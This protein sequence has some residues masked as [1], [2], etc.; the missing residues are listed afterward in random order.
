[1]LRLWFILRFLGG[2]EEWLSVSSSHFLDDAVLI[3]C[4]WGMQSVICSNETTLRTLLKTSILQVEYVFKYLKGKR[5]G[6]Y[7]P[8]T[9]N[10]Y[11]FYVFDGHFFKKWG[12]YSVLIKVILNT[13]QTWRASLNF[14]GQGNI[15]WNGVYLA[16][17]PY[18]ISL[19]N[20]IKTLLSLSYHHLVVSSHWKAFGKK[21]LG[22]WECWM[23]VLLR[24]EIFHF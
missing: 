13:V 20:V 2:E 16:L 22:V 19:L 3:K 14:P 5:N 11:I 1:M 12:L 21:G 15:Y 9:R 18:G 17:L 4:M 8:L 23:T 10:F 24:K 7:I 6:D